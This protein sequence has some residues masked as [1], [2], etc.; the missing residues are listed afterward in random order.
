MSSKRCNQI[1]LYCSLL[2]AAISLAIA[3]A[4]IFNLCL[5]YVHKCSSA[6]TLLCTCFIRNR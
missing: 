5:C 4:S 2:V 3:A 1:Y 6:V